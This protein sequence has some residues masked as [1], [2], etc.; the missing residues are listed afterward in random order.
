MG[1]DQVGRYCTEGEGDGRLTAYRL[2]PGVPES[3]CRHFKVLLNI[4]GLMLSGAD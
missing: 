1:F 4:T 3:L 2:T